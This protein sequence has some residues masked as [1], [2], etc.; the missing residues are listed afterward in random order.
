M[1]ITPYVSDHTGESRRGDIA[2]TTRPAKFLGALIEEVRFAED[3]LLEENG[4]EP[5]VPGTKEPV[6]VAEGELRDRTG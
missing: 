2:R 6:F 5:S 3:S 4:F 1:L